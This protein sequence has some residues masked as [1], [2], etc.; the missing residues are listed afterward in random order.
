MFLSILIVEVI[1]DRSHHSSVLSDLPTT[2]MAMTYFSVKWF[3][4]SVFNSN[5]DDCFVLVVIE[6]TCVCQNRKM[7]TPLS[8]G[9][10]EREQHPKSERASPNF[11]GVGLRHL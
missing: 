6:V 9:A 2:T 1:K 5:S 3:T 7:R 8:R 4:K 10:H 11:G